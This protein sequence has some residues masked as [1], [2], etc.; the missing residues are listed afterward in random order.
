MKRYGFKL[1]AGALMQDYKQA[2]EEVAGLAPDTK[3]LLMEVYCNSIVK[4]YSTAK[5]DASLDELLLRDTDTIYAYEL[6]IDFSDFINKHY[7]RSVDFENK[8][9]KIDQF[10]DCKNSTRGWILGKICEKD[11]SPYG[12]RTVIRV[13][14]KFS[15]GEHWEISYDVD[16]FSVANFPTRSYLNGEQY[17]L[18]LL[19]RYFVE[20]SNDMEIC[21][22]PL[23]VV[24]TNWMRWREFYYLIYLQVKKFIKFDEG[25]FD[26]EDEAHIG[27]SSS[28][29]ITSRGGKKKTNKV[30]LNKFK[31]YLYGPKFP[32]K[33]SFIDYSGR[34]AI[35]FKF[36]KS[37]V[38]QGEETTYCVGCELSPKEPISWQIK[39]SDV[40]VCVDWKDLNYFKRD[41]IKDHSS[42]ANMMVDRKNDIETIENCLDNL[43]QGCPEPLEQMCCNI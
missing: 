41:I 19:Q 30:R 36:L 37:Q 27:I 25:E 32:Y 26:D 11:F 2:F 23:V 29:S 5:T 15:K 7:S 8:E 22:I 21:N 28:K 34:C 13:I 1:K 18:R 38:F 10:I 39:A 20:A 12:H 3:Y 35:C 24:L 14:H 4:N 6:K 17:H 43:V 9:L 16:D 31:D 40:Q 33:L 42:Y